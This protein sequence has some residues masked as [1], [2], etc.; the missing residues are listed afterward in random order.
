MS[1]TCWWGTT[2]RCSRVP[3]YGNSFGVTAQ[4]AVSKSTRC[5]TWPRSESGQNRQ[6]PAASSRRISASCSAVR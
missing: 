3:A 1:F 5:R 4:C 6:I 2:S